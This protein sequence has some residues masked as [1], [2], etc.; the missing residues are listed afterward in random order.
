MVA[1]VYELMPDQAQGRLR[2]MRKDYRMFAFLN[3]DLEKSSSQ[4]GRNHGIRMNL[5]DE[6]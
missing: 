3:I 4:I 6:A 2:E 5:E 1:Q